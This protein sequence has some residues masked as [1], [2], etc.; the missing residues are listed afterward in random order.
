MYSPQAAPNAHANPNP[1]PRLHSH[2]PVGVQCQQYKRMFSTTRVPGKEIDTL[3][4][5]KESRHIVVMCQ[6]R[7]YKLDVYHKK[8]LTLL[9]PIEMERQMEWILQDAAA[10]PAPKAQEEL[11]I[12]ALTGGACGEVMATV[13]R[14]AHRP[15][16][17]NKCEVGLP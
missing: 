17:H 16:R 15:T 8:S 11:W 1:Q 2:N 14:C 9:T 3:V 4:Q 7:F 13:V 6:G 12:A 10:A 5:H